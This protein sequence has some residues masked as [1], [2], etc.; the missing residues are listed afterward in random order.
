MSLVPDNLY[1]TE[2]HEWVKIEDEMAFVG[3]TDFAQRELSDIVYVEVTG[4]GKEL[5]GREKFGTIEAV[6]TV[7][8]LYLP[9]S[10]E[11]IEVNEA[12]KSQPGLINEDP[13]GRGWIVKIK[14]KDKGELTGLLKPDDYKRHIGE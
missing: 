7:A 5:K 3:I 2:T 10:G 4:M 9:V 6:K 8:D 13:Y 11:I 12:V 1:Y 14:I